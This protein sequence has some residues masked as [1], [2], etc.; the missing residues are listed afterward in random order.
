VTPTAVW[1]ECLLELGAREAPPQARLHTLL[2][3][4]DEPQ[5]HYHTRGHLQACLAGW[6]RLREQLR[7]PAEAGLALLYHDAVYDPQRRDNEA[8]SADLARAD[9]VALGVPA[10]SIDRIAAL[11]Q[12][13]DHRTTTTHPDAA[14]VI[15]IDLAILG[16]D[17]TV[18]RRYAA[19]VR[20]EYAHVAE[21][22]WRTGRAAVLRHFLQR[23]CL[24]TSGLCDE[25]EVPARRNLEAELATL[26]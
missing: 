17:P 3:R 1:D 16:A 18:Y 19:D 24:F 14:A 10:A 26:G 6:Q 13:T 4:W 21:A 22:D 8:R 9:L 23:P 20:L 15:D 2:A 12:A 25:F 7:S 5:R 11:I